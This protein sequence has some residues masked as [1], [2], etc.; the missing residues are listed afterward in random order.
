MFRLARC[1]ALERLKQQQATPPKQ[2]RPAAPQWTERSNEGQWE[3][4]VEEMASGM[5]AGAKVARGRDWLTYKEVGEPPGR[6]TV[7]SKTEDGMVSV[8]WDQNKVAGRYRMGFDGRYD[9]RLLPSPLMAHIGAKVGDVFIDAKTT[10]STLGPK[11]MS[12]VLTSGAL[13][14]AR[15]IFALPCSVIPFW[16]QKVL[17]LLAPRLEGLH[18]LDPLQRH[19]DVALGMP[20]L[21]ALSITGVTGEQLKQV[22][23]MASLRRLELHCTLAA[24]L[25]SVVLRAFLP[26]PVRSLTVGFLTVAL[27]CVM[28]KA[29]SSHFVRDYLLC[30]EHAIYK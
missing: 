4:T 30:I 3:M 1:G 11:N 5:E 16:S 19:L 13:D 8:V 22:S 21:Q 10:S 14:K 28:L 29:E 15:F 24:P 20:H 7:V 9:L 25:P 6:A 18:M 17:E 2:L 27:C 23:Q 12:L 26:Q